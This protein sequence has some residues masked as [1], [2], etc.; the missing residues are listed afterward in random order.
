MSLKEEFEKSEEVSEFKIG[1]ELDLFHRGR[2][3]P[4]RITKISATIVS[5][6]VDTTGEEVYHLSH[7]WYYL[8]KFTLGWCLVSHHGSGHDV[9]V[10][11]KKK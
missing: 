7:S 9:E 10:Y 11:K 3:A 1:D 5:A 8:K 6:E 4:A 2:G